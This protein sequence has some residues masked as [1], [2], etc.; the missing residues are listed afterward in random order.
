MVDNQRGLMNRRIIVD[1]EIYKQEQEQ[2]FGRCWQFIGHE[3]LIPK[4]NDFMA[5]YM[6]E[7]PIL[8]TRDTKGKIHAFLNMCRH[9]GNRICRADQGNAPS[10][11]CTYHGWTFATDGKLVGVPGYKE[12]YFE[13]LDRSQWGLVEAGQLDTMYGLIFATWDKSAPSL[14]D[15]LGD[16]AW[17]MEMCYNRS[18][19]GIEVLPG[20]HKWMMQMNWKFPVDNHVGDGYHVAITHGSILGSGTTGTLNPQTRQTIMETGARLAFTLGNGHGV[21]GIGPWRGPW[22]KEADNPVNEFNKQHEAEFRERLGE[23]FKNQPSTYALFPNMVTS[24]PAWSG[25]LKLFLPRG[26]M[27][28]LGWEYVFV[29]KKAPKEYRD[30]IRKYQT[31]MHGPSGMME[32]DDQLPFIQATGTAKTFAGQKYPINQQLGLGHERKSEDFPG[33]ATSSPSEIGQR[34]FYGFWAE[35]MDAPSWSDI[36]LA[37]KTR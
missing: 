8:V 6:G 5:I 2:V 30:T 28:T 27:W 36:K 23:K 1:E 29:D 25:T 11:M 16:A 31:L 37:P 10:F 22:S 4:A 18:E 13:E 12:A 33:L 9:R 21:G 19:G 14:K 15:Y 20:V 32:S 3:S 17:H 26:P 24:N 35:L 7:D 34:G